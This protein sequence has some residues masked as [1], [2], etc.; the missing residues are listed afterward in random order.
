M[1]GLQFLLL[2]VFGSIPAAIGA[3]ALFGDSLADVDWLHGSARSQRR[4]NMYLPVRNDMDLRGRKTHHAS[5]S[6]PQKRRARVFGAP[7]FK[8]KSLSLEE[9]E[10]EEEEEETGSFSQAE[11]L[12]AITNCV[13]VL[14]FRDALAGKAQESA[15]SAPQRLVVGSS[16]ASDDSR[17]GRFNLEF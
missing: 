13:V 10:E 2:F 6:S 12:L 14:G 1:Y 7:L 17:I 11:S 5:R 3:G 8:K 15:D 4:K 16:V 9:E